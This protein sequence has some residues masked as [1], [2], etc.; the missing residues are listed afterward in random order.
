MSLRRFFRRFRAALTGR[1]LTSRGITTDGSELYPQP[2]LQVFGAVAHQVCRFHILAEL[3]KA[4]LRA[5]AQA[6]KRLMAQKPK[7]PR[8]RPVAAGAKR[9][10]RRR[11]HLD[12]K[13]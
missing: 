11:R 3:N 5:V 13:A 10:V 4:V 8:G 7:L 6:R 1:G 9:K 2:I 12:R